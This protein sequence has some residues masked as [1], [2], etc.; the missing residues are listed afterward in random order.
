MINIMGMEKSTGISTKRVTLDSIKMGS[1]MEMV[2]III[3]M[4][5]TTMDNGIRMKGLVKVSSMMV[6]L[7]SN[8]Y[9]TGRMTRR[10]SNGI[11]CKF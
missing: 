2:Y 11:I 6:S 5:A 8:V 4:V 10:L 7:A 1:S 9:L 3:E